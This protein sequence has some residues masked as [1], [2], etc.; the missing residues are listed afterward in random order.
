MQFIDIRNEAMGLIVLPKLTSKV[1][2][3]YRDQIRSFVGRKLSIFARSFWVKYYSW[4]SA[5]N[6]FVLHFFSGFQKGLA[7]L[8]RSNGSEVINFAVKTPEF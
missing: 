7:L 1:K 5:F 3:F 4:D 2:R 6:I 8:P